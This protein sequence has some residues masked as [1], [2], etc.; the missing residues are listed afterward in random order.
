MNA[1]MAIAATTTTAITSIAIVYVLQL[2]TPQQK[3]AGVVSCAGANQSNHA[4]ISHRTQ[5]D[6]LAEKGREKQ[7]VHENPIAGAVFDPPAPLPRSL[8]RNPRAIPR[9][10]HASDMASACLE[11]PARFP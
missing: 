3:A 8:C 11:Q 9:E 4:C 10:P 2:A 7:R 1:S 5:P 6:E